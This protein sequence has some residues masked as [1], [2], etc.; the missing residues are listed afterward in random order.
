M[1]RCEDVPVPRLHITQHSLPP[2]KPTLSAAEHAIWVS[3]GQTFLHAHTPFTI[4]LP[5]AGHNV[6]CLHEL[7]DMKSTVLSDNYF[8]SVTINAFLS[9]LMP[10]MVKAT[11]ACA[12]NCGDANCASSSWPSPRR[13]R[14]ST[15]PTPD[16][17]QLIAASPIMS[18]S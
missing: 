15:P 6:R 17:A 14:Q 8:N 10:D 18:E 1:V 13:R 5:A 9:S 4:K 16:F 2:L 3:W 11:I 12:D 7:E